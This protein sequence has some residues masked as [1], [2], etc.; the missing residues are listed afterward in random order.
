M[1]IKRT[2]NS[3]GQTYYH[4]AESYR[5]DGKSRHR[6]LMSLGRAKESRLEE[7]LKLVSRHLDIVSATQLAKKIDIKDTFILGPLLVIDTLF[8]QLG[9]YELLEELKEK[10]PKIQFD[11]VKIVFTLVVSRFIEPCSKLKLF[12]HWQKVFYPDLLKQD[13]KLQDIYRCL[14]VLSRHKEDIEKRL[15]Q[16]DKIKRQMNFFNQCDVVLYDLTTLRFE[17]TREDLDNL[18]KF[19]YSKEKRSD[20]TQ[21]VLGLLVDTEGMPLGFDVY[22]GNTFEGKTMPSVISKLREKF[23]VRRFIVVGDR[24]L[25]STENL[26]LFQDKGHEFIV[27]LKLGLLKDRY[28]EIYDFKRFEWI[29]ADIAIYETEYKGH[30]CIITWSRQRAERD[31]KTR[32]DII[33]KL[34][35]KLSKPSLSTRDFISNSNYKKYVFHPKSKGNKPI[36]NKEAISKSEQTD[37]F[38]GIITNTR[39][40]SSRDIIFNYKQLW[41]IENSFRELKG[42]LKTRPMFHWT[43]KR[44]LGHLV[45]CFIAYLCEAYLNKKLQ[46]KGILLK[47][48]AIKKATKV[49]PLSV[50]EAMMKLKEVRAI[51]VKVKDQTLWI[52]TDINGNAADVF[53]AIG[54]KIPS[55]QI[56]VE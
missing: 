24:G 17:S 30:R 47:D 14:D 40:L 7:I 29:N 43:D 42:T 2:K 49:R 32:E 10:H 25:F 23:Q 19:G 22:P 5:K 46:E 36:L 20:C 11:F 44:I 28:N 26:K 56:K 37:G 50:V 18:R 12:S 35:V 33:S 27:G 54:V 52:R 13:L 51:P 6:M 15:Y 34:S 1:F 39:D 53:K 16:K 55:K 21:V 38:F 8:K 41:K 3:R 48:E 31:K 9:L 4:I 45:L